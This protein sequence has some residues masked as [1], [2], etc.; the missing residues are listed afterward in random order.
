MLNS[1]QSTGSRRVSKEPAASA[2][3][4]TPRV[5]GPGAERFGIR[6]QPT[7]LPLAASSPAEP[8]DWGNGLLDLIAKPGWEYERA[9]ALL[10]TGSTM[11]QIVR[12]LMQKGICLEEATEAAELAFENRVREQAAAGSYADRMTQRHRSVSVAATCAL[13]GF[14]TLIAGPGIALR[15]VLVLSPFLA[16]IWLGHYADWK[17]SYTDLHPPSGMIRWAGWLFFVLFV[18]PMVGTLLSM[19]LH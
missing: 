17:G 18:I 10:R 9:K 8:E 12:H 1:Q 14:I 6:E 3:T 7:S 11:P 13:A 16:W 5:T 19:A 4:A 15:C 2:L